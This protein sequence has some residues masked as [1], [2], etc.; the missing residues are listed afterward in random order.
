MFHFIDWRAFVLTIEWIG[1][2]D[3]LT[4]RLGT[5]QAVAWVRVESSSLHRASPRDTP[6][7]YRS[8]AVSGCRSGAIVGDFGISAGTA[9]QDVA[10]AEQA[11]K[12]FYEKTGYAT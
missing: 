6:F 5:C 10:V 8:S 9:V 7:L 4:C 12:Y 3:T 1:G 2:L 11:L